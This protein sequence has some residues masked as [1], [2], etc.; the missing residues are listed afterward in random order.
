MEFF[1]EANGVIFGVSSL[2]LNNWE[3]VEL[4]NVYYFFIDNLGKPYSIILPKAKEV[5]L[6]ILDLIILSK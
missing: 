4:S 2:E 5:S 3:A 1:G 6:F